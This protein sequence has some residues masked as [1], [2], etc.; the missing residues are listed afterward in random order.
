MRFPI[1][2][3]ARMGSLPAP[4]RDF[5]IDGPLK[6]A[7]DRGCCP[8]AASISSTAAEKQKGETLSLPL[9]L[10]ASLVRNQGSVGLI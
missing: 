1:I 10:L 4:L 7:P 6:T 5:P 3:A 9:L 2:W 8:G